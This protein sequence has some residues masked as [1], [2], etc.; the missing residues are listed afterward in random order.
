MNTPCNEVITSINVLIRDNNR[1]IYLL[2]L[3]MKGMFFFFI[4]FLFFIRSKFIPE[5]MWK[6][7]SYPDKKYP[8]PDRPDIKF[9]DPIRL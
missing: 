7:V 1:S 5:I 9:P 3:G 2:S 4:F 8:D 6:N